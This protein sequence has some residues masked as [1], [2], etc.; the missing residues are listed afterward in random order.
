MRY[1]SLLLVAVLFTAVGDLCAAN[2]PHA[3]LE[4]QRTW[5]N[6]H[7]ER[8]TRIPSSISIVGQI[9]EETTKAATPPAPHTR[10]KDSERFAEQAASLR[11]ELESAQ[12]ELQRYMQA[13]EDARDLKTMTGGVNFDQ[14]HIGI[15]LEAG[16]Q[17]LQ[18]RVRKKETELDA[19]EGLAQRKGTPPGT[20][21]GD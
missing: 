10:A 4:A 17:I 16:I 19:L 14:G 3:D 21:R 15:S 6:E 1:F 9:G 11:T 18:R 7:L 12:S 13:I 8:L 20:L 2:K 5:T